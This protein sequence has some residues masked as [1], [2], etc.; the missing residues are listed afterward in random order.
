MRRY[1]RLIWS[2]CLVCLLG[3]PNLAHAQTGGGIYI[4]KDAL[5]AVHDALIATGSGVFTGFGNYLIVIFVGINLAW[6]LLK[7]MAM[8][9]G[10]ADI[11]PEVLPLTVVGSLA[12][13]F[14][15]GFA[16]AVP[17]LTDLLL[18][19]SNYLGAAVTGAS[20]T[21]SM[22][23]G[24]IMVGMLTS[25]FSVIDKLM[26]TF[27]LADAMSTVGMLEIGKAM[28]VVGAFVFKWVAILLVT[29]ALVVAFSMVAGALAISQF[30]VAIAIAFAP[31]FI[32]MMLNRWSTMFFDTWLR[33]AVVA[34]FTKII[35]LLVIKATQA[36]FE[37]IAQVGDLVKAQANADAASALY[38]PMGLFAVAIL[39]ALVIYSLAGSIA[40]I[41]GGLIGGSGVGMMPLGTMS[42]GLGSRWAGS[43]M[44][45]SGRFAAGTAKESAAGVWTGTANAAGFADAWRAQGS[46][47]APGTAVP[48]T[49]R[50]GQAYS[51]RFASRRDAY[52]GGAATAGK[53][54]D[55][56]RNA[57]RGT[58]VQ[59]NHKVR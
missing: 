1:L 9:R 57:R 56:L 8:G 11:V 49:Q 17:K 30:T 36:T 33:F 47:A 7:T 20:G 37:K 16:G 45:K 32:P 55:A 41:A 34:M 21:A 38:V 40:N 26:N 19:I 35:G 22:K 3:F 50:N 15:N 28:A 51:S 4:A 2:V 59:T 14:I 58:A 18:Q 27:N 23:I 43:G 10:I 24:D 12:Y 31:V 54:I 52:Q 29:L 44:G 48:V 46:G 53:A 6:S 42:K 25:M 39:L 5:N 13:A